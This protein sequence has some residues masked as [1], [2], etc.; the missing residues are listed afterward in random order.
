VDVNFSPFGP[1]LTV[2]MLAWAAS[3]GGAG[4]EP[5]AGQL[6]SQAQAQPPRSPTERRPELEALVRR[7]AGRKG[8]LPTPRLW[9]AAPR[10]LLQRRR[11]LKLEMATWLHQASCPGGW[12]WAAS[13]AAAAS[14][15]TWAAAAF[16]AASCLWAAAGACFPGRVGG[17]RRGKEEACSGAWAEG[18]ATRAPTT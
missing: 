14:P 16:W 6:R 8:E 4:P 11:R 18:G 15:W 7:R 5:A 3:K 2:S 10:R 1:I 13:R 17:G 9:V 12:P